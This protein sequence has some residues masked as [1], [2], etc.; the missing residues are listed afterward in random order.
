MNDFND[1]K[2]YGIIGSVLLIAGFILS[3]FSGI[4]G[5]IASVLGLVLVLIAVKNI[6]EKVNDKDIFKNYLIHFLLIIG[7]VIAVIAII[8]VTVGMSAFSVNE[9]NELSKELESQENTESL[10]DEQ[11]NELMDTIM[12]IV[13]G[14]CISILVGLILLI[15]SAL[16]LK[17]SFDKIAEYTNVDLFK[18][19][20]IVYLIGVIL[21]FIL[22][23]GAIIFVA[24]IIQIIS[25]FRLPEVG[26]TNFGLAQ[27]SDNFQI[28]SQY[29]RRCPNCGRIIPQDAKVCPYCGKNFQQFQ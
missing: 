24:Y 14:C 28:N 22:I 20:A 2:N 19:T 25:F 27:E 6:S 15:I 3:L 26:S 18:T 4:I 7:A 23:G 11:Y 9:L 12:P 10:T 8:I 29:Q 5:L 1:E 21:S 13:Q 16:F 17:K